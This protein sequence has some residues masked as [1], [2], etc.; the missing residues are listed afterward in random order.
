[1]GPWPDV[2]RS[3][4]SRLSEPRLPAGGFAP[5][6]NNPAMKGAHRGVRRWAVDRLG[7]HRPPDSGN[8]LRWRGPIRPDSEDMTRAVLDVVLGRAEL[9]VVVTSDE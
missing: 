4:P 1:M 5:T 3:R 2:T 8:V 6:D 9:A 7:A